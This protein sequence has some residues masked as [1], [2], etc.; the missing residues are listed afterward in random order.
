MIEFSHIG[1]TFKPQTSF[2][3][4]AL[5]DINLKIDRGSF[6]TIIGSNGSGKSILLSVLVGTILPT[7]GKVLI[8]GQNVSR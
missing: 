5:I 6:V 1:I 4:Q 8:N 2:E 7:E 3:K